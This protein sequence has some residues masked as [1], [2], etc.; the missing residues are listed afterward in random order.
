ML[1]IYSYNYYEALILIIIMIFSGKAFRD[2]WKKQNHKW[3][4]KS[5]IYGSISAISF[6][7][8]ILLN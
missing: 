4:L 1:N 3:V 2:N 5:W 7:M 8:I 6:F